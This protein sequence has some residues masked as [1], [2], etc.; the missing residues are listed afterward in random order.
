M[1]YFDL[2]DYG[3]PTMEVIYDEMESKTVMSGQLRKKL[4]KSA[5]KAGWQ[6]FGIGTVDIGAPLLDGSSG[7]IK[8]P[9]KVSYKVWMIKSGKT[10]VI[11]SVRPKQVF[12]LAEDEIYAGTEAL[13]KATEFAMDTVVAQLQ[14]KNVR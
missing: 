10:R 9:A 11:A 8:V 2:T 13:N 6:F 12:A 4:L 7:L 1:E 14:K 3:A 5:K